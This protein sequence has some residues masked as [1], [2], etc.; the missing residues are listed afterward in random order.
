MAVD[1]ILPRR[2]RSVASLVILTF[3]LFLQARASSQTASPDHA[4]ARAFERARQNPLLLETFLRG[5]PKGGDLHMHMNGAVYA[6][7][8]IKDAGEDGLCVDTQSLTLVEPQADRNCTSVQI[9]AVDI[10]SNQA[11]Y[12]KLVDAFSM[13]SFV[14]SAGF[15]GHDQFFAT[16]A[17]FSRVKASHSGEWLAEVANRA[18][19]QNESYL[20]I[21]IVP[22]LS[23]AA[24][25][26]TR[27]DW[28]ADVTITPDFAAMRGKLLADGLRDDVS[29]LNNEIAAFESSRD[30]IDHCGQMSAAPGC[31]IHM[32]YLF[33]LLR[34]RPPQVVFAQAL[35]GFETVAAEMAAANARYVGINLV[36]P[37]DG[38]ISMRDY[39]LQMLMF[40]YLHSVYPQVHISLHAGELA[41]GLVPPE[42]LRFHIREAVEFGHAERIGHGV[43]LMYEDDPKALLGEMARKHVMVEINLTSNDAILGVNGNREP[44]ADY[45]AGGVPVAFSTDDEGVSRID[46]TREYVRAVTELGLNYADLKRSARTSLEHSFL[47]GRSLWA[48]PDQF[49]R[50]VPD[51]AAQPM[52]SVKS[53]PDCAA[54]LAAS[55]RASAQWDLESRYRSFEA[56]FK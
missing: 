34:G 48:L 46:L 16:F 1:S 27:L 15:S 13:R 39:H 31:T 53:T 23:H 3:A 45:L 28:P 30:S 41:P 43:D 8:L 2:R 44:L 47:P 18:A 11:L 19:R 7:T 52:G 29:A 4:A 33:T 56:Q 22:D 14:P 25:L 50:S 35:L 55:P 9:A 20:E 10:P 42:G 17:R 36:M 51:C 54:Y 12:T 37:E 32:R 38:F 40:D 49:T 6:E 5:M 24:A 21:M 26:S